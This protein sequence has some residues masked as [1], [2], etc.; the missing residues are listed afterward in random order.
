M[1]GQLQCDLIV[2]V[3]TQCTHAMFAFDV[4]QCTVHVHMCMPVARLGH[5]MCMHAYHAPRICQQLCICMTV[6][7]VCMHCCHDAALHVRHV[8]LHLH[9]ICWVHV[10]IICMCITRNKHYL[11]TGIIVVCKRSY[12]HYPATGIIDV[13]RSVRVCKVLPCW[14]CCIMIMYGRIA[15]EVGNECI[16]FCAILDASNAVAEVVQ[17]AVLGIC[18]IGAVVEH[19]IV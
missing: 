8:L 14:H 15:V 10:H 18:S 19:S 4:M 6:C 3:C 5:V 11:L 1:H 17:G 9:L 13:S 2:Q 12:A 7:D 16:P